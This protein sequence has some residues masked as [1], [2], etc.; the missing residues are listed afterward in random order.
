MSGGGGG[1]VCLWPS[2]ALFS[3][4]KKLKFCFMICCYKD[5]RMLEYLLSP[6]SYFLSSSDCEKKV[7]QLGEPL[8]SCPLPC[9]EVGL[10]RARRPR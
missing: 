6:R 3:L 8:A 7:R 10:G 1:G 5:Q 9:G 2:Q 4:R